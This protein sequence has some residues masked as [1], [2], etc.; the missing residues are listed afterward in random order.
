[1]V[2]DA[3]N[4]ALAVR[5][6]SKAKGRMAKGPDGTNYQTLEKYSIAELSEIVKDRLL[7]KKMDYVRRTYIPKGKSGK[8]RPLGI[9]SVWDKLVEKCIQLVLEPYCETKFVNSSFGF[10]E[11][12][13]AHNALAK[14]KNQCES[15]PYVLSIDLQDYFGTIDP[16]ITYREMWHIGIHDQAILNYVYQFIKKGY[17]EAAC[18][19]ENPLGAPQGSALG[20]LISNLYLHRFDVWLREQGDCWH[21]ATVVKFHGTNRRR[22]MRRTNLKIGIH[23]RYAD[24]ILVLCK[25]KGDAERFR[26]SIAKYLTRNMKLIINE[27]KSKIYDLTKER[28]KY[29]GYE[30][31]VFEQKSK[32]RYRKGRFRVANVLP[33]AKEDEIVEKCVE[34]LKAYKKETNFETVHQ[35]NTYVVGLHNYYRGMN[36][37]YESFSKIG[38]RIYKLF[39]HTMDK[40]VKFTEEQSFKN[41]FMNGRYESWGRNGYYCF[42]TYP[43][44][45]INWANWSSKLI[46]GQKGIVSRKNPYD[47]GQ[48]KHKPG[49]SLE[50][51]GY[52]V[53]TSKY[54]KNSRLAMFR[55]SKYS[56]VKGVSYLS[57][58]HVPVEE[59]HCHHIKL[60]NKGGTNDFDNLCVLSEAEHVILHS[61]TPERLYELFP[62]RGKRIEILISRL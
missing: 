43:I 56:S 17:Y 53:N 30:F 34:L 46:C 52:L 5:Q 1:M 45:Q 2:Y 3:N 13:G 62:K 59:Y 29:L 44:I 27:E 18:K 50:D 48:K 49:V 21:D 57:G 61:S 14:V 58:E 15:M 8:M 31:Y 47:Y 36:N 16:N 41:N 25:D 19:V 39:Y 10:R 35:W 40:R 33:K 32:K 23:V 6:L 9:C 20:P 22:T 38:W 24:D 11:Q 12:V 54:I 37:F 28:M 4:V 42:E 51:V 7:N 55:I 26:F 60:R